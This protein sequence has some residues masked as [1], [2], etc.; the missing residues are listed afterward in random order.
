MTT[1]QTERQTQIGT[2]T[3]KYPQVPFL[4][5]MQKKKKEREKKD[6][7]YDLHMENF[8]MNLMPDIHKMFRTLTALVCSDVKAW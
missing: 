5:L 6:E 8:Q 1:R 2:H 7:E 4:V 3:D